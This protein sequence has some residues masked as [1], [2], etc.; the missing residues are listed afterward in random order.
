MTKID[1]ENEIKRREIE[2]QK[3]MI[4]KQIDNSKSEDE[5]ARLL[6]QMEMFDSNLTTQLAQ[7]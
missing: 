6:K 3:Q 4:Q 5:K 7:Q 1:T 2:Q